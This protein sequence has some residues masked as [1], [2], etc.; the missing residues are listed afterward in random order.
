MKKYISLLTCLLVFVLGCG[1]G[2]GDDENALTISSSNLLP[3]LSVSSISDDNGQGVL[4]FNLP[5]GVTSFQVMASSAAPKMALFE[6]TTANGIQVLSESDT[7][8]SEANISQSSPVS[9]NYPFHPLNPAVSS[10]NYTVKYRLRD[11]SGNIVAGQAVSAMVF[12][13]QDPDFTQGTLKLNLI[14][15]GGIQADPEVDDAIR[16]AVDRVTRIYSRIGI[17][18]DGEFYKFDGPSLLPDPTQGDAF[19]ASI[20]NQTRAN[21][22]NVFF[23]VDVDGD[24]FGSN[25]ERF[26]RFPSIPGPIAASARSAI[27]ISISDLAGSDGRFDSRHEP[28]DGGREETRILSEAI[29]HN[30]AH[31]LGLFHIGEFNSGFGISQP[32]RLNTEKCLNLNACLTVAQTNNDFGPAGNLMFPFPLARVNETLSFYA[33]DHFSSDQVFI[34]NAAVLVN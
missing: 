9:F 5:T 2:G 21:A 10:G 8:Y 30:V 23:G 15:I 31:Y 32:D 14:S 7:Q 25:T 24:F 12:L 28:N 26:A 19:Y 6:A 27:A 20:T 17:T 1:G 18:I 11:N 34:L 33:R 4:Q 29:M 22:V 3:P 13:K 16:D